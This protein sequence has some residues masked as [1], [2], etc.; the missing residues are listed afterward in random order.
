MSA[1]GALA[2]AALAV[3]AA[4]A[5]ADE[6]CGAYGWSVQRAEGW[7]ADAK[8][9]QR[10][11][12]S[13]LRRIDRAVALDLQPLSHFQFFLPPEMKAQAGSYAG[14]VTFFGVPKPA[15][16][17]VTLSRPGHVDVFENGARI[18]PIAMK[19]APKCADAEVSARYAL[20]NGDLVLVQVSDVASTSIK[21][22]FALAD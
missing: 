8:L 2:L 18:K 20:A 13:R 3:L 15:V 6:G 14:F 19:S 4:P 16:Y 1:R 10:A 17:Q 5:R 22:A 12:G 9:P 7:F 21:V 11:S